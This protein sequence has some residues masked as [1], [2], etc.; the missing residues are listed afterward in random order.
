M[1]NERLAGDAPP[2]S[3]RLGQTES[4]PPGIPSA[5][6]SR[7]KSALR[8]P[9]GASAALW[10]TIYCI[11][12]FTG[13]TF[14][15][16]GE[17]LW[18]LAPLPALIA[19]PLRS[20]WYLH[21]QPPGWNLLVGSL[22][23]WS[24]LNLAQSIQLFMLIS[25]MVLAGCIATLLVTL[26]MN[27]RTA[28]VIALICSA[29]RAMLM[30]GFD[31]LYELP[32]AA[33]LALM[34]CLLARRPDRSRMVLAGSVVATVIAMTRSLYHPL[35][36]AVVLAVALWTRRGTISRRTMVAAIGIPLLVIGGWSA[37]NQVLFGES[38][39]SSWT[40]MN[41]LRSVGP[42]VAPQD[43]AKLHEAGTISGVAVVGPFSDYAGYEPV[44]PPC[45]ASHT[46]AV[47]TQR[48][49]YPAPTSVVPSPSPTPNFN[50]ECYLPVFDRAGSD[51]LALIRARPGAW[52]TA[53]LW[54]VNNW[55]CVPSDSGRVS[56]PVVEAIDT[57]SNILFVAVAHPPMPASWKAR[58]GWYS[59]HE[60]PVSIL[61]II[62]TVV[63]LVGGAR[64]LWLILRSR[65][66][67]LTRSTII[68]LTGFTTAWTFAVGV[69]GELGEQERFRHM[70]DPL[71][72][73]VAA[74]IAIQWWSSKGPAR[75][76]Q[77]LVRW[78]RPSVTVPV[79]LIT[80]SL[81]VVM[82]QLGQGQPEQAVITA[83]AVGHPTLEADAKVHTAA[84]GPTTAVEP[85]DNII[86]SGLAYYLSSAAGSPAAASTPAAPTTTVAPARP[87]CDTIVHLGD[88]NL[89]M[90]FSAFRDL[91]AATGAVAYLD[92]ANGRGAT[93]AANGGT[94]AL[95]VIKDF[96][97][98]LPNK[99][100]CWVIALSSEDAMETHR[101]G[102]DPSV[103]IRLIADAIGE[104]PTVW[105][106]PVLVSATTA[107]SLDA[108]TAYNQALLR[109]VRDRPNIS[110][111]DWQDVA[112]QYLDQFQ[113]DGVHYKAPLYSLLTQTVMA[114][115]ANVWD[116][117]P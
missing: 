16:S 56:S 78:L 106:T 112:L 79:A 26:G 90:T 11:A 97:L 38:S 62:A 105:I 51:A 69:T 117:R 7:L 14:N 83:V 85:T 49:R 80:L 100:V 18:Q 12:A 32:V 58:S 64:H 77:R 19:H 91:Y 37:K 24:P 81:G 93:S 34:V 110:V 89:G 20:V 70:I 2:H 95:Q 17:S 71:V 60:S 61:V 88:S 101:D 10:A 8:S 31:E 25:G 3:Y 29:N 86:P 66:T 22:G 48:M 52:F 54:A 42:A 113:P 6:S 111:L 41:L 73:A 72:I 67:N 15:A 57:V 92:F 65:T 9:A 114:H 103:R 82:V 84:M 75:L 28:V 1:Y 87:V 115:L 4:T 35:W 5:L 40:G 13:Q 21:I 74:A 36:L 23:R 50:Y 68:A 107:W 33:L 55:F 43:I 45:A 96:R 46:D 47:L 104:E 44:M 99:S 109:V 102:V 108:S 27:R 94:S 39:L 59:P 76:R 63:V 98:V 30:H 53:R 116:I